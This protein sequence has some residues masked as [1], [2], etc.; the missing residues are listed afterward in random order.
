MHF[1]G[2][3]RN[4][5]LLVQ[6]FNSKRNTSIFLRRYASPAFKAHSAEQARPAAWG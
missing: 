4:S 3:G 1:G 2:L 5:S 6:R